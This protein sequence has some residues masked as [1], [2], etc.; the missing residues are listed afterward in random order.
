M[1][2]RRQKTLA[3]AAP[4]IGGRKAARASASYLHAPQPSFECGQKK[5]NDTRFE[6]PN[7]KM[8]LEWPEKKPRHGRIC[9]ISI[10]VLANGHHLPPSL[11]G[12]P[13][14]SCLEPFSPGAFNGSQLVFFFLIRGTTDIDLRRVSW[15]DELMR[16]VVFLQPGGPLRGRRTAPD[17]GGHTDQAQLPVLKNDSALVVRSAVPVGRPHPHI[18]RPPDSTDVSS[19]PRF[20]RE[21]K[22]EK[23]SSTRR[24]PFM[25][26][27][28]HCRTLIHDAVDLG[29]EIKKKRQRPGKRAVCDGKRP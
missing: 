4:L 17:P 24:Q 16:D 3:L 21:I 26:Q 29:G 28:G 2:T 15:S 1:R 7:T 19:I 20:K 25:L 18:I 27:I 6:S 5:S 12:S 13:F 23:S 11:H 14:P 22:K 8:A 9:S 10:P